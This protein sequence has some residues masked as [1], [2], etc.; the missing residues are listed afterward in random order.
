MR[1]PGDEIVSE[2][3]HKARERGDTT[4]SSERGHNNVGSACKAS[5][6]ERLSEVLPLSENHLKGYDANED[7]LLQ[8]EKMAKFVGDKENLRESSVKSPLRR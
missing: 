7:R 6:S 8:L 1:E 5:E 2:R 4:A 3:R